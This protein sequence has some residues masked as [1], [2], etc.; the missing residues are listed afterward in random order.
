MSTKK[1]SDKTTTSCSIL[2]DKVEKAD[3]HFS[4]LIEESDETKE[5]ARQI[6][7]SELDN[8][9]RGTIGLLFML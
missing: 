8:R 4:R 5:L 9:R 1:E 7:D 6:V 2:D 3:R